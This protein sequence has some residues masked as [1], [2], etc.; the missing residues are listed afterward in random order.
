M[1]L[2]VLSDGCPPPLTWHLL[3][4]LWDVLPPEAIFA[5]SVSEANMAMLFNLQEAQVVRAERTPCHVVRDVW[6]RITEQ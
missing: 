6:S 4:Y 2:A 1:S 3:C 5:L